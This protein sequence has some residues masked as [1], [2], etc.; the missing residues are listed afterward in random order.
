MGTAPCTECR[1]PIADVYYERDSGVICATCHQRLATT[2][3]GSSSGISFLRALAFGVVASALGAGIYF[4]VVAFTG[5]E[6]AL[7]G[8]LAGFMVGK[9]VRLGSRGRGGRRYQC[10][11]IALT[12]L[13]IAGTYVPFVMKG[14]DQRSSAVGFGALLVFAVFAPVLVGLSHVM[15]LAIILIS[16]LQAWRMNRRVDVTMSGPHRVRVETPSAAV[17]RLRAS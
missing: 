14:F 2:V 16:L 10:L 12:Y 4:A 15:E 5:Y 6:V 3:T 11:A 8:I 7:V 13:A 17:H 1:G 9:A